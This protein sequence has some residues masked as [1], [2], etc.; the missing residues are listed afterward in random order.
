MI[1]QIV[2]FRRWHMPWLLEQGSAEGT[3]MPYD[4][5]T[6]MTLE[7]QNS[8]SAVIDGKPIACGG[9]LQHWPGRHQAW[10]YM[11]PHTSRHMR[12]ITRAVESALEK[13]TGRIELTV[14][15]DFP[16]GQ[17]WAKMLGF[18][19]ETPCLEDYGP[20]GEAHIGYVRFNKG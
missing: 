10:T 12:F 6:L 8:W 11:T 17:R 9:T 14:R 19:V 13:V 16:Q 18:K 1:R 20:Q 7:K 2:P 15:A 3:G 5:D 4:V